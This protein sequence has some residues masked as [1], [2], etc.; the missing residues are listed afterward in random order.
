L[1]I[2]NR[3][4]T[5]SFTTTPNPAQVGETV[6]FNGSASTDP[7]GTI[8][9]YEWDLDGN[10]TYE[11]SAGTVATTSRSYT[12]A[13]DRTIG[14]RVTDNNGATATT[15]RTI[16]VRATYET[17]VRATAGLIDYWRLGESTGTSLTDAIGG[18]TATARNGVTLGTAGN[19]TLDPN[20]AASFDGTNDNAAASVNLSGTSKVTIEFWMKWTTFANNDDLA[21]EFTNNNTNSNG[22]FVINPNSTTSTSRFEVALGR[23]GSRNNVYFTRPSAGV[24]HHYAF[25]L[26]TT[27]LAA[28]QIIPYVDGLPVAFVKGSSGTGAGNFANSTLNFM[29]RNGSSLF[30]AGALDEVAIYNQALTATQIA[31][32]YAAR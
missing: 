6:N 25:V 29:S 26:N 13:G 15:T 12:P 28:T 24:W 9:K 5:A 17:A 23:N 27:A 2:T 3:A 8:A 4:P 18:N 14:L 11:T 1:T 20:T 7:D 22:A 19:L 30:G 21:F 10:G 16:S 31:Q 32:H